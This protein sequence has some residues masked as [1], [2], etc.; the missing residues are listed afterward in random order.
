M[1]GYL[2]TKCDDAD[3]VECGFRDSILMN[4]CRER[5]QGAAPHYSTLERGG[6]ADIGCRIALRCS[7]HSTARDEICLI[8][9][10]TVALVPCCKNFPS[11]FLRASRPLCA[12]RTARR[13]S[14]TSLGGVS[15][16]V[17]YHCNHG[18]YFD[19]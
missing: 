3:S 16:S 19:Y 14:R 13:S 11:L 15:D 18:Q 9:F 10:N 6:G 12:D 17:Q 4:W 5:A 1:P 8:Y 7:L 2:Q